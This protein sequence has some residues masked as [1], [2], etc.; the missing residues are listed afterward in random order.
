MSENDF[1]EI[2]IFVSKISKY[3][4]KI[5]FWGPYG[6]KIDYPIKLREVH[7]QCYATKEQCILIIQELYEKGHIDDIP[8]FIE[9][10]IR[11]FTLDEMI[12]FKKEEEMMLRGENSHSSIDVLPNINE[13]STNTAE[14]K[15][16]IQSE[17]ITQVV[18]QEI[19]KTI[20]KK[21]INKDTLDS[22]FEI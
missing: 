4:I 8:G 20:Q 2:R 11:E 6:W 13:S 22:L 9:V 7:K 18:E 3:K 12:E 5:E 16:P 10:P 14:V 17:K 19:K 1:S 15:P 21:P